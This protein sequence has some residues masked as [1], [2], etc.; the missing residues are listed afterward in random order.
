MAAKPSPISVSVLRPPGLKN[1]YTL[2]QEI[3]ED[4]AIVG[5]VRCV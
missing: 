4:A 3:A 2:E 1:D 5:S